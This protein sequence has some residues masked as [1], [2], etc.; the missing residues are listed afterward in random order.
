MPN[1]ERLLASSGMDTKRNPFLTL[2]IP[3]YKHRR[4]LEVVLDSLF[5]Q[6]YKGFEILISDDCSPDDSNALIPSLLQKSDC[7]FRY[8]AQTV[9]LGYDRNVRFCLRAARGRYVFLLGNDDAL[10]GPDTLEKVAA[11][12]HELDL[13]EVVFTNY[14]DWDSGEVV[15]RAHGTCA[16]GAGA[17]VAVT[18]FR[19]F[20]FVSGLIYDQAAAVRHET[21]RWDRSIYYQ[22]YIACRI[23]AAGGRLGALDLSA[24]RKDVR[25]EK[26]PV[27][28]YA[29]KWAKAPWS[30]QS[31]HTGLDSVIRVTADAVLPLL[32]KA[33]QSATLRRIVAKVLAF[34]Y[35]FW[36]FEYRRVSRW[37][38]AAGVARGLWPG[39]LLA[40]Y[41]LGFLNRAYLYALYSVVTLA[42]L[43]LPTAILNQARSKLANFVRHL[44]QSTPVMEQR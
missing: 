5:E 10:A 19:S 21:D 25:V 40:E 30:F 9:N 16:L 6:T 3:H 31:R 11:M 44:Q 41:K 18:H 29:S 38:F 13:P 7:A 33:E 35:P 37:S 39:N 42:A 1:A 34:T 22:I 4:Y 24:V 15:R 27:P 20:S 14:E 36:L 43:T 26:Q 32:P 12:L 23:L 8:Y 2:A 17:A 28:N